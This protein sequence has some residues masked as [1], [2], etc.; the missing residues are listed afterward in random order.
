MWS[1]DSDWYTLIDWFFWLSRVCIA[2]RRVAR[3]GYGVRLVV[4]FL[5]GLM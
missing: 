1:T 5:T 2:S 4:W 3:S